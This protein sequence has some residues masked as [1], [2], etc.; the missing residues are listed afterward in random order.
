MAV[1]RQL[2]TRA[3]L[4]VAFIY[5][6]QP[7]RIKQV[8]NRVYIDKSNVDDDLVRLLFIV[9]HSSHLMYFTVCYMLI[10]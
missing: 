3:G 10:N 2:A 6:K 9:Q 4:Y 5:A 8:L 1:P 7:S